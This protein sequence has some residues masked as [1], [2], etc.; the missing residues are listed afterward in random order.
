MN[1]MLSRSLLAGCCIAALLA[2]TSAPA[3]AQYRPLPQSSSGLGGG[4]VKGEKYHIEL[5]G[6]LWNPVP[7]FMFSSEGLGI[8]GSQIDLD[9]DLGI[10][11][12]QLY[13]AR[14]VL[15][16]AKKHKLRVHYVPMSYTGDTTLTKD[17][18]FN[19]ILYPVTVQ[20]KTDFT[21]TA[22]RFTYEYDVIYRERGYLGILLESKYADTN[23]TLESP[24]STEYVRARAPIPAAG[25]V[26]RVYPLSFVSLTGEFT[27]FKLPD[28]VDE[29]ASFSSV[30]FDVY[31]TVN[32]GH[33]IGIQ[34][35]YRSIDMAFG[36]DMDSGSIKL[37]GPYVGGVIRF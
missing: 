22:Y 27:Y 17:I 30:D 24:I 21:W 2:T 12:K 29:S 8:A 33:N 36:I 6:N 14:L 3:A 16:P 1:W 34:A 11:Q 31:G 15:R 28:S 26:G 20:V 18:V 4:D 23:L 19:G 25:L 10:K 37:Q 35:G 7:D 13:E 9:A 32:I 5:S